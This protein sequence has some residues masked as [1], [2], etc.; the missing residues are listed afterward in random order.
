L[1]SVQGIYV[2]LFGRPADPEGLLYWM[3]E[4]DAGADLGF[5]ISQIA[6]EPEAADRFS[7]LDNCEM[8]T[9]IYRSLFG[10][11]PEPEGLAWHVSQLENGTQ[12]L[13]TLAIHI[14]DGAQGDDLAVAS[15]KIASADFFTQQLDEQVEIDAYVGDHAASIGRQYLLSV[16]SGD[17]LPTPQDFPI[18]GLLG[19]P[20]PMYYE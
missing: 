7:G 4:A 3:T 13:Q 2:A 20:S 9:L 11:D 6:A 10:R 8:V 17:E 1:A 18:N 16:Y 15:T 5:L 12:S 14:L 19:L